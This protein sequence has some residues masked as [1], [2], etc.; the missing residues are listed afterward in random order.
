MTINEFHYESFY[1]KENLP[2]RQECYQLIAKV[3]VTKDTT[4]WKPTLKPNNSWK[5]WSSG[6]L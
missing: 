3:L 6:N 4:K 2:S 5:N 1:K